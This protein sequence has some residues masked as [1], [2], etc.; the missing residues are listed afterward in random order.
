M[1]AMSE[2]HGKGTSRLSDLDEVDVAS[3]SCPKQLYVYYTLS[4]ITKTYI[5]IVSFTTG[6]RV[7]S[8][9]NDR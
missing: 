7:I 1:A 4:I 9:V 2:P 5:V 3:M 6:F 8:I